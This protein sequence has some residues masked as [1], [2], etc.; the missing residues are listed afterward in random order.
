MHLRIGTRGS[1]LALWQADFVAEKLLKAKV[2]S[3]IVIIETKGDVIL[4]KSLSKIGSKGVFTEELEQ[5]LRTNDIDI[6]VHSAKDLSSEIV[7]DLA[8]IAFMER[9]MANDVL[10]SLNPAIILDKNSKITI[11]TSSTRRLATLRHFYPQVRTVEMR[12]NLQTRMDK[13]KN[14]VGDA[15]CD[16]MILAFAGV[17]RMKYNDFIVQNLDLEQFTPAVGQGSVAIQVA[18]NLPKETQNMLIQTLNHTPTSMCIGVERAFLRTLQGGCS[19]PVFGY[20]KILDNQLHFT[21]G[22]ISLDGQKIIKKTQ[23]NSFNNAQKLGIDVANV[24]LAEGAGEILKEI[25]MGF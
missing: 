12:G 3:E 20:C 22:I 13:L 23:T 15:Q 5:Q 6:A 10:I 11:G 1:K 7:E 21:G 4:D 14:N 8:I 17:N 2:T 24:L 19:V 25:K 9:E 16:A 18:K